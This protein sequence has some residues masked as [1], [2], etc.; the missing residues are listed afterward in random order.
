MEGNI[1][2]ELAVNISGSVA[3]NRS[4]TKSGK[5]R[6]ASARATVEKKQ[7]SPIIEISDHRALNFGLPRGKAPSTRK[8]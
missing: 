2:G 1:W 7:S 3:L 6:G 8:L 5:E 4:S